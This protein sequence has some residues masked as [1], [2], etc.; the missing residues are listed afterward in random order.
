[1]LGFLGGISLMKEWRGNQNARAIPQS[2]RTVDDL[3]ETLASFRRLAALMRVLV[4]DAI[5][6]ALFK[7][8]KATADRLKQSFM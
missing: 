3:C 1:M 6:D 7:R 8:Q 5:R 4:V 2:T